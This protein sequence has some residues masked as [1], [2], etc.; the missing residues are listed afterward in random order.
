MATRSTLFLPDEVARRLRVDEEQL[1]AWVHQGLIE[2]ISLPPN[3]LRFSPAAV[4]RFLDSYAGPFPGPAY[5]A[6]RLAL[7]ERRR[8]RELRREA[9]RAQEAA[10][11][12]DD[13]P[14]FLADRA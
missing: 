8:A 2:A 3:V 5:I 7:E 4:R 10:L 6:N 13:R 11:P 9:R 1:V 12:P 14:G